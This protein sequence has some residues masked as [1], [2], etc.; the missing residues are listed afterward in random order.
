MARTYVVTGAGSGIGAKTVEILRESGHTVV[1][2]D[3]KNAEVIGDLSTSEGRS[4][5]VDAAVEA[6]SG[7]IDAVIACAGIAGGGPL[8]LSVNYYGAI[9][10]VEGIRESLLAS[11]APR[12]VI[13]SS[14]AAVHPVAP[15]LVD[16][17]LAGDEAASLE[18]AKEYEGSPSIYSSSK[19]AVARWVRREAITANWAGAGIALNTVAPGVV[20]TPMTADLLASE[21]AALVDA[22]NPMPL[23]GHQPASSI[24]HLLIWLASPENSHCTGQT[25]FCDGG[26]EATLRGEDTFSFADPVVEQRFAG[27]SGT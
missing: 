2:V 24:A 16:S 22:S 1:G 9:G 6:T 23:N 12:A 20:I 25:F 18:L 21:Y 15:P 7:R 19:R 10:F 4:A 27:I 26:G 5:A 17:L 11:E 3:L 8:T 14:L 13:V